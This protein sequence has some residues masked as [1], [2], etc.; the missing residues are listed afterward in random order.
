M[1]GAIH[2]GY[3][4]G[5]GPLPM[6]LAKAL[7]TSR[8]TDRTPGRAQ[9]TLLAERES[10]YLITRVVGESQPTS[11]T[12]HSFSWAAPVNAPFFFVAERGSTCVAVRVVTKVG[13]NT[14]KVVPVL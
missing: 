3:G 12:F 8:Q 1:V 4:L 6:C 7:W 13:W 10:M 14:R 9:W 11:I 2:D 5:I